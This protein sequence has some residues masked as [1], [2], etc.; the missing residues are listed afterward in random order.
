[1]T[2]Y[3]YM[4]AWMSVCI[5]A[6]MYLC[7]CMYI[8]SLLLCSSTQFEMSLNKYICLISNMTHTTITQ[9]GHIEPTFFH[10]CAIQN[11]QITAIATSILTA[12]YVP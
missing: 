12:R 8:K 11:K 7:P 9:D 4:H 6:C 1:M 3:L 10:T 5:Y 2:V